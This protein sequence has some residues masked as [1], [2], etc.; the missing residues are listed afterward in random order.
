MLV[1]SQEGGVFIGYQFVVFVGCIVGL[2]ASAGVIAYQFRKKV[3]GMQFDERQERARGKA[4]QYGFFTLLV[5]LFIYAVSDMAL[6]RWCDTM[7]GVTVCAAAGMGVF[8]VT[9][10]LKDAYLS[11]RERPRQVMAAFALL[12]AADLSLGAAYYVSGEL[13]EDGVLTF[14]AMY[15][16]LG[17]EALVILVVYIV[18]HLLRDREEAE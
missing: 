10:I 2:L 15:P 6:V 5:C 11:L 14:R 3:L 12:A 16:I 7:A 4:Y 1:S 17:F 9:C 8:A 13:V 18:H